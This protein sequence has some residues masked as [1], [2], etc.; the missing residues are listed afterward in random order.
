MVRNWWKLW[1]TFRS[2]LIFHRIRG[3]RAVDVICGEACVS[4]VCVCAVLY[5]YST[6]FWGVYTFANIKYIRPPLR[7][8]MVSKFIQQSFICMCWIELF[9]YVFPSL[10]FLMNYYLEKYNILCTFVP[11]QITWNDHHCIFTIRI[12]IYVFHIVVISFE[13]LN[14]NAKLFIYNFSS[15]VSLHLVC[16]WHECCSQP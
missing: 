7:W 9:F 16:S 13:I 2:W 11:S 4:F 15:P 1:T 6:C 10:F 12:Q 5:V 14:E 3:V 8:K